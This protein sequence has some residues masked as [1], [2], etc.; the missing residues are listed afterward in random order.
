MVS[1]KIKAQ[2]MVCIMVKVCEQFRRLHSQIRYSYHKLY[3]IISGIMT[4]YM[5]GKTSLNT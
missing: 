4:N 2:E 1:L 5:L 3:I